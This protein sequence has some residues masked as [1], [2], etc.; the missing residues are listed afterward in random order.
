MS[1]DDL[2]EITRMQNTIERLK[3]ELD[4]ERQRNQQLVTENARLQETLKW[5]RY[6]IGEMELKGTPAD[7]KRGKR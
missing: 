5:A 7:I 6:L 4:S 3:R 1:L 2:K